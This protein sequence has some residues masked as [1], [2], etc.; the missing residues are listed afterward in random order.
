MRFPNAFSG[1]SK[2]HTAQILTVIAAVVGLVVTVMASGL[3]IDAS[4]TPDSSTMLSVGIIAILGLGVAVISIIALIMTISGINRASKDESAFKLALTVVILN[5]V[6]AAASGFLKEGDTL[7]P[8]FNLVN[9]LLHTL[10]AF[11]VVRGIIN[12]AGKLDDGAMVARGRR[13]IVLILIVFAI[14]LALTLIGNFFFSDSTVP[15]AA[16]LLVATAILSVI[17]PLVYLSYLGKAKK[18]LV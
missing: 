12:L 18:M 14:D 4:G 9:S 3:D 10:A 11:F 13:T 7:A 17:Q 16:I 2:I 8:V 15:V 5:I 6:V 1:V